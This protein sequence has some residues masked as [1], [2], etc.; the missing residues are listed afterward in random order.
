MLGH[1]TVRYSP[2]Q[3]DSFWG[4]SNGWLIRVLRVETCYRM[5]EIHMEFN[6]ILVLIGIGIA[7]T[8]IAD[9]ITICC[10]GI[11]CALYLGR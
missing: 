1:N 4:I 9:A 2:C 3:V 10:H 8:G 7:I 6:A 5:R 11:P